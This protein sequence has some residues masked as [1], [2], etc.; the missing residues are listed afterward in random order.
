MVIPLISFVLSLV[1]ILL[2]YLFYQEIGIFKQLS[3]LT[4]HK[5][6]PLLWLAWIFLCLALGL[7]II[8]YLKLTEKNYKIIYNPYSILYHF[9]SKSRGEDIK[10][11][12]LIRFQGDV[13]QLIKKWNYVENVL[14]TASQ[15]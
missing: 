4:K 14:K 9:E 7:G 3:P 12:N 8:G 10:D 2:F 1:L 13:K 5:K 15:S 11:E 6:E